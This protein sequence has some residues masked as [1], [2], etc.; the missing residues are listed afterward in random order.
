MEQPDV[1]WNA[2]SNQPS[3]PDTPD[4]GATR[5]PLKC[6]LEP[7]KF[8]RYPQIM[9]QPDGHWNADSN[10]PSF[11]DTPD[12]QS[13]K[14]TNSQHHLTQHILMWMYL[15]TWFCILSS[16]LT[17]AIDVGDASMQYNT[18]W[19]A[20][21]SHNLWAIKAMYRPGGNRDPFCLTVLD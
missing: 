13:T 4:H 6:R 11:P 15:A 12:P 17:Q 7:A 8:P 19:I 14:T 21:H 10:Q 2:D 9:E 18:A 20:Q 5:R 3:F 16:L 1:H